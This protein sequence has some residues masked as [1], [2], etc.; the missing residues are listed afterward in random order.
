M[1]SR[2]LTRHFPALIL[3]A[4]LSA[5]GGDETSPEEGHTPASAAV[6]VG[7]IEVTDALLLPSGEAVRVEV[8]FYDEHG[9]EIPG[10]DATHFASLTFT[11]ATLATVAD[12]DGE[13]FQKDVTGGSEAGT[14][15]Y[16]VGYGHDEAADELSFGPY[17]A[18]VVLVAGAAR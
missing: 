15:T 10:I 2:L 11:P 18:S 1:P 6:F 14:G 12:V 17:D 9:E 7:G 3:I 8:K 13:H 5:C 4:A 16:S